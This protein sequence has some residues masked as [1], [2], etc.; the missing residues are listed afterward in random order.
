MEV[1]CVKKLLD[2]MQRYLVVDP[3]SL[4]SYR[5]YEAI[6]SIVTSKAISGGELTGFKES[7]YLSFRA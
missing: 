6:E 2:N 4:W 3:V 1:I 7:V 5:S